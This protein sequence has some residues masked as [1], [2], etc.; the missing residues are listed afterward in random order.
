LYLLFLS[1]LNSEGGACGWQMKAAARP[2]HTPPIF[3]T[4][5][6]GGTSFGGGGGRWE[7]GRRRRSS[8]PSSA[9]SFWL[10]AIGKRLSGRELRGG[11]N[12]T[13]CDWIGVEEG[14]RDE[15][16]SV[17]VGVE[18][19]PKN[20]DCFWCCTL[21]SSSPLMLRVRWNSERFFING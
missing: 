15:Q 19:I 18:T 12:G 17:G 11:E 1:P 13:G 21:H 10:S 16:L 3:P 2:T 8:G 20:R 6:G 5:L 9:T 14:K 7:R 4:K